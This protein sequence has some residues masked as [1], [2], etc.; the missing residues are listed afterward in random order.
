VAR[1]NFLHYQVVLK[2]LISEGRKNK[3]SVVDITIQNKSPGATEAEGCN[4]TIVH[5]L[6][7]QTTQP[8][9][10]K[11]KQDSIHISCAI[12]HYS[13][14]MVQKLN[15]RLIKR[16]EFDKLFTDKERKKERNTTIS[17]QSVPSFFFSFKVL[18]PFQNVGRFDFSS[19]I[20]FAMH[21]DI[22]YIPRY[23]AN[24]MNLKKPKQPT[25]R[26]GRSRNSLGATL[27]TS[28]YHYHSKKIQLR[29]W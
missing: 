24:T 5:H 4:N 19:F 3:L 23:I 12:D 7:D 18:P 21:L 26:N 27:T 25:F 2:S 20:D 28:L 6:Q 8:T 22:H 9:T 1:N 29:K 10:C 17:Y 14:N 16:L 15:L 13:L 11:F